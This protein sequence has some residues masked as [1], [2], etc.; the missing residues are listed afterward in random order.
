LELKDGR[1]HGSNLF[2]TQ[3]VGSTWEVSQIL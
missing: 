2:G 1:S 3:H